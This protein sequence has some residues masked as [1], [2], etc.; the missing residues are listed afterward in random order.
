MIISNRMTKI[1][2]FNNK[3]SISLKSNTLNKRY[4]SHRQYQKS[5][6]ILNGITSSLSVCMMREY[7]TRKELRMGQENS[8][9]V[10]EDKKEKVEA[11]RLKLSNPLQ[12]KDYDKLEELYQEVIE[13][14]VPS[15]YFDLG[16]LYYNSKKY[17][18]AAK[19]FEEY[20]GMKDGDKTFDEMFWFGR[21][22]WRVQRNDEA[23]EYIRE[24]A[25]Q[26][27]SNVLVLNELGLIYNNMEESAT[28]VHLFLEAH[29]LAPEDI[30]TLI[31]ISEVY[32]VLADPN[33]GV[34]YA[35][36]AVNIDSNLKTLLALGN[37]LAYA[38][39]PQDAIEVYEKALKLDEDNYEVLKE[40]A[41]CYELDEDEKSIYYLHQAEK[42]APEND[43][44]IYIKLGHGYK[45]SEQYQ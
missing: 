33:N 20:F 28:A 25:N 30:S 44:E 36:K 3:Q 24:C 22:L 13:M 15:L 23:L 10:G 8:G 27:P 38:Q 14:K 17:D 12:E 7:V 37:A 45:K 21:T 43:S 5:K 2:L 32:Q 11:L 35:Q 16:K 18:H 40:L 41:T 39:R 4:I 1:S 19:I 6:Y 42:V 31:N 34:A 29:S 26:Q 9:M